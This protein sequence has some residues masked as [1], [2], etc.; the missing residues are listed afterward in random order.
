M[1]FTAYHSWLK[2]M[3]T[4]TLSSSLATKVIMPKYCTRKGVA[5]RRRQPPAHF[6]QQVHQRAAFGEDLLTPVNLVEK[7]KENF[8][9]PY[10]VL[11]SCDHVAHGLLDTFDAIS[12]LY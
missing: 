2:Y 6:H 9:K 1:S 4:T 5:R 10:F 7:S 12:E 3:T 11:L 8:C